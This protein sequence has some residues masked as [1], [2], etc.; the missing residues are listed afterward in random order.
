[1]CLCLPVPLC[2]KGIVVNELLFDIGQG[3][4]DR[5]ELSGVGEA[6]FMEIIDVPI[7]E[8]FRYLSF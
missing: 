5:G 6:E 2:A 4:I 3:S 7:F 1:M 8:R